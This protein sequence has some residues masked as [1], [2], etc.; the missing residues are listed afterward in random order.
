MIA[1]PDV[2]WLGRFA[3]AAGVLAAGALFAAVEGSYSAV[4][5]TCGMIYAL[6]LIAIW[7]PPD[8]TGRQLDD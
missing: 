4:G 6:G 3:T 2:N 8:T 1:L 5:A 7:W